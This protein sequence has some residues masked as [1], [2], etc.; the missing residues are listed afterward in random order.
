[1]IALVGDAE[2]DE[3]NVYEALMESW[4]H[5]IKN[6][7]WIIDYNRQS[8]DRA[9]SDNSFRQIERMFRSNGW[10]VITLKYG[11]KQLQAFREPGGKHLKQFINST[12]N[13]MFSAL[14]FA[15]GSAF[16]KQIEK[17]HSSNAEFLQLIGRYTDDELFDIMT[18]LGG[19]CMETVL[20]AYRFADNDERTCFIAYT[21]K[22]HGLPM[23]GHRD[24][25]GLF[26]TDEQVAD[27]QQRHGITPGREWDPLEGIPQDQ[28]APAQEILAAAPFG[29]VK[30]RILDD[31]VLDV[32]EL[33]WKAK[34]GDAISTQMAFGHIMFELAKSDSP[35][36]ARVITT[37]PDV[38][39]STNLSAF[40]NRRGVFSR[41]KQRD[42]FKAGGAMSMAKW[43]VSPSGQHIELGIAENN[44]FL[45]LAAAGLSRKIFGRTLFPVGTLYDPF[46]ARGL[47]AL[48]YGCYMDSRFMVVATPS[49]I[50]LA[51]EG[52][53]HQSINS[54]LIGMGQPNLVSWEPAY[55]DELKLMLRWS[56]DY[57]QREDGGSTY[58]R[59]STRAIPQMDREISPALAEN[60]IKGGYWHDEPPT[61]DT[62]IVVAFAGVVCPQ[63]Q[64]RDRSCCVVAHLC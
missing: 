33:E 3:G 6:N 50:T 49:G 12:D 14:T 36:A 28:V 21:V 15:G 4:K 57:M 16:R 51:P 60:I 24:N 55:G 9:T 64:P 61:E 11:K 30:D 45:M 38:T 62:K 29:Q 35:M 63:H 17:E 58:L 37:S 18:N 54:P 48:N 52:G 27:L 10:N 26:L 40:V 13:N 19:H 5:D 25:H 34:P 59:L 47:D 7:W 22:G 20:E 56:F 2:L 42:G 44:L 31:G 43:D 41:T 23:A 8:L 46:I 32:P 1:M 53:A 39:T